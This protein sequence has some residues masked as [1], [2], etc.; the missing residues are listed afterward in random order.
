M[1]PDAD[2]TPSATARPAAPTQ[3]RAMTPPEFESGPRRSRQTTPA[4]RLAARLRHRERGRRVVRHSTRFAIA[5]GL[6]LTA[7]FAGLAYQTTQT[8]A[9]ARAAANARLMAYE[10]QQ[11]A[12]QA[13]DLARLRAQQAAL[14]KARAAAAQRAAALRAEQAAARAQAQA[15][16]QAAANAVT[17]ATTSPTAPVASAPVATAPVPSAPVTPPPVAPAP[18]AI[19][20]PPVVVSGGS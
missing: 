17:P 12:I 3:S 14:E 9:A 19:P 2:P 5:G 10:R 18:V 4:A 16:A 1:G 11:Y 8:Q 20:T 7:G 13:A 15:Q 6:V